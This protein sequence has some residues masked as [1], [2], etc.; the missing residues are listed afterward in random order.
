MAVKRKKQGQNYLHT[1]HGDMKPILLIFIA[2]LLL[3]ATY[4][5]STYSQTYNNF[6]WNTENVSF[7]TTQMNVFYPNPNTPIF[8]G[9]KE[10]LVSINQKVSASPTGVSISVNFAEYFQIK[11]GVVISFEYKVKDHTK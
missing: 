7:K 6:K 11:E 2:A 4:P 1:I 8:N 9:N 10:A 3:I 5:I